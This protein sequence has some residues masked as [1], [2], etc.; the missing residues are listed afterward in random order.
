MNGRAPAIL[1]HLSA[2]A[3]AHPQ[4]PAAARRPPRADRVGALRHPA[5]PA[6][7]GE[8]APEGAGRQRLDCGAR[9]RDEP[10]VHA[11]GATSSTRPRAGSGSSCASRSGRRRRP[12]RTS[13]DCRRR[14]PSAA[15]SRRSSSPRRPA[16][17]IGCARSCSAIAFISRRSRGSPIRRGSSA[18]SGCGAGQVTRRARAVR[19]ARDGRG[20]L[21]GDAAGGAQASAGPLE[22]GPAPRRARSA[23][24]RR[25]AARR[26]RP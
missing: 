9:R 16:S 11:H 13:G 21:G 5:A 20:R 1:D 25:R 15:R 26:W 2:L 3:D 17:G 7:H 4:P 22:R 8:P 10:P 19:R 14:S 23:A 18:T 6:V 12:R 24:D